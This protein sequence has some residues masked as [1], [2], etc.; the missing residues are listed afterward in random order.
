MKSMSLALALALT[1]TAT[2]A[3]AQDSESPAPQNNPAESV[4]IEHNAY[5]GCLLAQDGIK[6]PPI[7]I[8]VYSCGY[9]THGDDQRFIEEYSRLV[10]ANP[11]ESYQQRIAPYRSMLS[12][13][14]QYYLDSIQAILSESNTGPIAKQLTLLERAAVAELG[15]SHEDFAVLAALSTAKYSFDYWTR[16]PRALE[17]QSGAKRPPGTARIKWWKIFAVVLGDAG[18]ALVGAVAGGPAGAVTV[19]A[20][21]SQGVGAA[22]ANDP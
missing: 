22:I 4:G 17:P 14:Q 8:L 15:R 9:P 7:E 6:R 3:L 21:A 10:P 11:R 16:D 2:P 20:A 12:Q 18:G 5:L 1:V 19:G 13:R